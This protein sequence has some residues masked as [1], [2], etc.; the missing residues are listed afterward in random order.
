MLNHGIRGLDFFPIPYIAVCNGISGGGRDEILILE[1]YLPSFPL[2]RRQ[3][4]HYDPLPPPPFPSFCSSCLIPQRGKNTVI[5]I[6]SW[7]YKLGHTERKKRDCSKTRSFPVRNLK[8]GASKCALRACLSF[9]RPMPNL[10]Q[11]VLWEFAV[12]GVSKLKIG[13]GGG[14]MRDCVLHLY[15]ETR[16]GKKCI[17][18]HTI[19]FSNIFAGSFQD[20]EVFSSS[21]EKK[22]QLL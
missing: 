9:V 20:Q 19:L 8:L 13:G 16:K 18:E 2:R 1:S 11:F 15:S 17:F 22:S 10:I 3:H 14:G 21:S 12:G 4:H 5:I 6:W 7:N